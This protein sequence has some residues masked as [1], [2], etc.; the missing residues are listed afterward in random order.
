MLEGLEQVVVA[1][2]IEAFLAVLDQ[3]MRRHGD[4][5]GGIASLAQL[6][7][8]L[9]SVQHGHLHVHQDHVERF[10]RLGGGQGGFDGKLA[11]LD[12]HHVGTGVSQ[13]ERDQLL[14]VQ[15]VLGQEDSAVQGGP[16]RVGW[17]RRRRLDG[18]SLGI[19]DYRY[20]VQ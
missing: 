6:P 14:I 19:A 5:G 7:R 18:G 2:G 17:L 9:V 8:G 11:V 10:A 15:P 20:L 16:G 1:A 3:R 13:S 12:R 4:D